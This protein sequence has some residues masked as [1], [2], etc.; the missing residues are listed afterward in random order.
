MAAVLAGSERSREYKVFRIDHVQLK[1]LLG[2][3][4]N[5]K[6][7]SWNDICGR[8]SNDS[9]LQNEVDQ[10]RKADPK[11]LDPYQRKVIELY[12]HLSTYLRL[13]SAPE[14][15]ELYDLIT[16]PSEAQQLEAQVS[17]LINGQ[18]NAEQVTPSQ[19]AALEKYHRIIRQAERLSQYI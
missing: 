1:S 10:A 13:A 5:E 3:P 7:F 15:A 11:N 12:H 8:E 4:D 19:R 9:R 6:R 16:H 2:F 14:V 17:P 18:V